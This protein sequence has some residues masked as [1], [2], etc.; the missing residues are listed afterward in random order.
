MYERLSFDPAK[1]DPNNIK[2]GSVPPCDITM[3]TRILN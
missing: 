1:D 2:K 3:R